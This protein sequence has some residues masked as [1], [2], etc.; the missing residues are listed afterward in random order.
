[1][2]QKTFQTTNTPLTT[3]CKTAISAT[4]DENRTP[5]TNMIPMIP[6]TP[7]TVSIPMQ[8]A[9][10]PALKEMIPE[11]FIEYSFEERR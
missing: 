6:C 1:M 7:S 11:G 3:P 2:L 9:I 5:K 4:Q 10:T 8:T